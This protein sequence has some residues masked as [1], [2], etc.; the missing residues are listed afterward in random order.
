MLRVLLLVPELPLNID[1]IKGGVHSAS[2]NLIK[3]FLSQEIFIRVI[4]FSR[5]VNIQTIKRISDKIEIYYLPEGPFSYHTFNYLFFVP[6]KLKSQIRQFNPDIIHY[7][8][9]NTFMFSK[10]FGLLH[11]NYLLTIHGMSYD[12]GKIKIKWKDK[13]TWYFNAFVQD[14]MYPEN[15]I[16]LSKYSK[17]KFNSFKQ[18][19]VAVIPNAVNDI[20]FNVPLKSS[21]KNRLLYIGLIDVNKNLLFLLR[22]LSL[23]IKQDYHYT[24][25][26]IGD[27]MSI[28]Y[29]NIIDD[30]INENNLHKHIQFHG[31]ISQTDIIQVINDTD[32]LIVS[33]IH[34]SLPMVIAESMASGIV[35]VAN[36]VGGIPE[37]ITDYKTGFLFSIKNANKFNELLKMLYN[38][39]SI[40]FF[41]GKNAKEYSKQHY[42]SNII[43]EK[44]LNFYN[45]ILISQ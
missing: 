35:I 14:I 18:K 1:K 29:K 21:T 37:M 3:G 12:E 17:N 15:I 4:S 28:E 24:L 26:I 36:S 19:N 11:K 20:Y 34:E 16:H 41:I 27:F 5:E 39:H 43:A 40:C 38:N 10:V 32:I 7:E 23:L 8:V 13:L 30:F 44:T 9:G 2:I 45:E 25:D 33:S 22:Q 6:F 42:H 31:W